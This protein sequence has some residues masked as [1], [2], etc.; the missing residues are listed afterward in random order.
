[1]RI[2]KLALRMPF[3]GD[4]HCDGL[5]PIWRKSK[6]ADRCA[7]VMGF[8]FGI[9]EVLGNNGTADCASPSWTSSSSQ[10]RLL[11]R[12][13]RLRHYDLAASATRPGLV[14]SAKALSL[15]LISPSLVVDLLFKASDC[16]RPWVDVSA[17]LC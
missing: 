8:R 4:G 12:F 10:S 9:A 2:R 14:A 13:A 6:S 16:Q 5:V 7:S 11:A 17:R 1:M 3:L 15:A